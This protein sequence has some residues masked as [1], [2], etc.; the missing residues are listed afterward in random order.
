MNDILVRSKRLYEELKTFITV[1]G[2]RVADHG[3]SFHDD[4]IMGMAI[5]IYVINY[6]MK[7]I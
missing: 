7:K 5:G 4:S 2:S 6:D 3:R 1:P